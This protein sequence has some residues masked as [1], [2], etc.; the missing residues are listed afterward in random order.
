[1]LSNQWDEI[2]KEENLYQNERKKPV[3]NAPNISMN[4]DDDFQIVL[5]MSQ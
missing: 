3:F 5:M 4:V 1:M 2:K